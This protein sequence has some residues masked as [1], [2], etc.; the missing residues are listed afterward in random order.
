M[1]STLHDGTLGR[2]SIPPRI[3]RGFGAIV[4]AV[5]IAATL[6]SLKDTGRACSI[7]FAAGASTCPE[8][9]RPTDVR[10]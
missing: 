2:A 1:D 7:L 9:L 5:L 10:R 8:L 3:G 4:T 6:F